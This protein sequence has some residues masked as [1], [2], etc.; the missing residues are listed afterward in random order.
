[1][2]KQPAK[3]SQQRH[4]SLFILFLG[5]IGLFFL[6]SFNLHTFLKEDLVLGTTTETQPSDEIAFWENFLSANENY[7]DGWIELAKLKAEVGKTEEVKQILTKIEEI[8]PNS[9]ELEDLKN[10][11]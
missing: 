9:Q 2:S 1:M 6:T 11:L 4:P 3:K 10:S 7:L 5:I 8:D